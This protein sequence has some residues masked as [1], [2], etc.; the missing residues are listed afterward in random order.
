MSNT[1]VVAICICGLAIFGFT[2]FL[3]FTR[4]TVKVTS[5]TLTLRLWTKV[6]VRNEAH[7]AAY[8]EEYFEL[9]NQVTVPQKVEIVT[10]DPVGKDLRGI[11]S[12]YGKTLE[13]Y[14]GTLT[15]NQGPDVE[16]TISS[17]TSQPILVTTSYT[18]IVTWTAG[19][20]ALCLGV[21]GLL[22]FF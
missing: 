21:V 9:T 11:P 4:N 15:L 1:Q 10:S 7:V 17:L 6:E 8:A 19:I 13:N 12:E 22:M 16:L 18:P 3:Q 5:K 14:R 2:A 20:V